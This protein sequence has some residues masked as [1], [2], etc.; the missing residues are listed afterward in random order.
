MVE[1]LLRIVEYVDFD[2]CGAYRPPARWRERHD[3]LAP[4]PL[5]NGG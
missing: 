5:P 2:T 1:D 3:A 4:S